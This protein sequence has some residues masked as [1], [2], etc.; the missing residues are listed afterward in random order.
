MPTNLSKFNSDFSNEIFV[1][2]LKLSKLFR[3]SVFF[4]DGLKLYFFETLKLKAKLYF[5][6]QDWKCLKF[7][8]KGGKGVYF[9]HY[10]ICD[11]IYTCF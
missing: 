4:I 2:R 3:P 1:S 10:A 11:A 8:L 7:E 6:K 9:G 5:Q